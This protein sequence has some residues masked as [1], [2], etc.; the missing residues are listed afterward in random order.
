ML[1]ELSRPRKKRRLDRAVVVD[2]SLV[3]FEDQQ[4]DMELCTAAT[5]TFGNGRA[6]NQMRFVALNVVAPLC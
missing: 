2:D 5:I 6:W 1:C 4:P 3:S